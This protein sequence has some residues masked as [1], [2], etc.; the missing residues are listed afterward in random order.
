[1]LL[2]GL[3][4]FLLNRMNRKSKYILHS[5]FYADTDFQ[6]HIFFRSST[7]I[8]SHSLFLQIFKICERSI[9]TTFAGSWTVNIVYIKSS[10]DNVGIDDIRMRI[11]NKRAVYSFYQTCGSI[12]HNIVSVKTNSFI[13]LVHPTTMN[14]HVRHMTSHCCHIQ[15]YLE[16]YH[17]TPPISK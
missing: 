13:V 4:F 10:H 17:S 6:N 3:F 8:T 11:M 2:Y 15:D 16:K 14:A 1:M 7:R 9:L 12:N 5:I